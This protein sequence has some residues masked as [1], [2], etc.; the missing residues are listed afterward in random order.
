MT[1]SDI[2]DFFSI[3]SRRSQVYP[4]M[5]GSQKIPV[6]CHME[7]FGCGGGGGGWTLAMKINGA[8]ENSLPSKNPLILLKLKKKK[9][10]GNKKLKAEFLVF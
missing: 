10:K 6:F 9:K 8:K 4:L 3:R 1:H 7:N 2:Y 5:F